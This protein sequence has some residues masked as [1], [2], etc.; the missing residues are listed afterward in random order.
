MRFKQLIAFSLGIVL[1]FIMGSMPLSIA[2][3]SLA[4]HNHSAQTHT[5]GICAWMCTA[6]QTISTDS[7]IL[8]PN[9]SL[10]AIIQPSPISSILTPPQVFLPARAPPNLPL[11]NV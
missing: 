7:H 8:S 4:H 10:L 5:T 2:S 1:M 3:H 9:F 6:A 11:F